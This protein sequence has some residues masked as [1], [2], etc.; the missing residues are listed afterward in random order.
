MTDN[1]ETNHQLQSSLIPEIATTSNI[2][3]FHVYF[4]VSRT[5]KDTTDISKI[6]LKQAT[7]DEWF[8]YRIGMVTAS[9]AHLILRKVD[10]HFTIHSVNA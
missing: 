3:E 4:K 7:S 1:C 10:E 5:S 2:N 6:R 9:T 8:Q